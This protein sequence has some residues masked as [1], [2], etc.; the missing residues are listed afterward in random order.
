M[1]AVHIDTLASKCMW[2][3]TVVVVLKE[4]YI[5]FFFYY[6]LKYFPVNINLI[7]NSELRKKNYEKSKNLLEVFK[8]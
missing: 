7:L 1:T 8:L 3:C 6:C 4:V 2:I 5:D